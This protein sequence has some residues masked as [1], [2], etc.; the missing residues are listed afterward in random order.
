MLTMRL[1]L[2]HHR[3]RTPGM[4]RHPHRRHRTSGTARIPHRRHHRISG[5]A[6]ILHRRRHLHHLNP[7]RTDRNIA[8]FNAVTALAARAQYCPGDRNFQA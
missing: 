3:R 6:R 7:I 5:M 4:A 8:G 1:I 2:R